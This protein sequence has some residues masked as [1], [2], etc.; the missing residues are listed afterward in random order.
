MSSSNSALT[1]SAVNV[2]IWVSTVASSPIASLC[3]PKE[4][5]NYKAALDRHNKRAMPG[6]WLS[7]GFKFSKVYLFIISTIRFR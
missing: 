4:A 2:S 1:L 6:W 5:Q 3:Q 7:K